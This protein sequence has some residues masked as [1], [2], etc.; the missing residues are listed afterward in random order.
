M[1]NRPCLDCGALSSGSRCE[2][3]RLRCQRR[4]ERERGRPDPS[5]RGYGPEYRRARERMLETAIRC[6][7]CGVEFAPGELI[8]ADHDPPMR[9]VGSHTNLV[10][11]HARCNYGWSRKRGC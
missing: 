5:L 8:T 6:H 7:V 10:P 4:R 1:A 3:C 2:S 11:A 9:E